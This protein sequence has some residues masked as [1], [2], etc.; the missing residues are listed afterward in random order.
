MIGIW[1]PDFQDLDRGL[2]QSSERH[3]G[4]NDLPAGIVPSLS[5]TLNRTLP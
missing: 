1:H 4:R 2:R 5:I 3:F